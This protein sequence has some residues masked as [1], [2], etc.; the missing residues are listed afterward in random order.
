MENDDIR[1]YDVNGFSSISYIFFMHLTI[2]LGKF[3]ILYFNSVNPCAC[4]IIC[5]IVVG[6]KETYSILFF[7][8]L[9]FDARSNS[10]DKRFPDNF[11]QNVNKVFLLVLFKGLQLC[12]QQHIVQYM[13][14]IV[15]ILTFYNTYVSPSDGDFVIGPCR[16]QRPGTTAGNRQQ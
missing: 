6:L 7:S 8:I 3:F 12:K 14:L 11:L 4:Y 15:K 10:T 5:C 16:L 9:G 2:N 1:I 13:L